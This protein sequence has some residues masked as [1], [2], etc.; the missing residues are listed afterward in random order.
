M[1]KDEFTREQK[2]LRQ[3]PF[4]LTSAYD[5]EAE[6]RKGRATDPTQPV[7]YSYITPPVALAS[8][9]SFP[10]FESM[11]TTR[12][13]MAW[14]SVKQHSPVTTSLNHPRESYVLR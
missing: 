7:F 12:Y 5:L 13:F 8:S 2:L 3:M 11:L 6:K 9:L 10:T 4:T 1:I 14:R